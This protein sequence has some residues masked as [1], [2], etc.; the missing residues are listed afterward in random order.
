MGAVQSSQADSARQP[1]RRYRVLRYAGLTEPAPAPGRWPA[2][3][4]VFVALGRFEEVRCDGVVDAEVWA[5]I[6][7]LGDKERHHLS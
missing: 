2:V 5:L 7:L 4:V 3:N 1:G 6:D